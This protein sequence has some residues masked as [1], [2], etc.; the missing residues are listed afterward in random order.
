[1]DQVISKYFWY[2]IMNHPVLK[3]PD[4]TKLLT[5]I[6]ESKQYKERSNQAPRKNLTSEE[7]FVEFL[8]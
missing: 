8:A 4:H 1:M 2:I 7:G 5:H 6:S 3:Y